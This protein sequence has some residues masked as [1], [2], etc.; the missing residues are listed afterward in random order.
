M[1]QLFGVFAPVTALLERLDLIKTNTNDVDIP[2]ARDLR[3]QFTTAFAVLE[4]WTQ[5]FHVRYSRVAPLYWKHSPPSSTMFS[6]GQTSQCAPGTAVEA[7][8]G[9]DEGDIWFPTILT[10]S[11][12]THIW[13]FRIIILKS[14]LTLHALISPNRTA[15]NVHV[16]HG[17]KHTDESNSAQLFGRDLLPISSSSSASPLSNPLASSANILRMAQ[18]IRQSVAYLLQPGAAFYGLSVAGFLVAMALEGYQ[19]LANGTEESTV[20]QQQQEQQEKQRQQAR[21]GVEQCQSA[22]NELEARGYPYAALFNG[23]C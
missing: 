8:S 3:E 19:F 1:H 5:D 23:R 4:K 13:S 22:I 6:S 7:T 10:A 18:R 2:A 20:D 21:K 14:L 15:A 16:D 12:L 11:A 9:D 17:S